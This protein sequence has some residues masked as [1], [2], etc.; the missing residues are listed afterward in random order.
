VVAAVAGL[1][2]VGASDARRTVGRRRLEVDSN[3]RAR[4]GHV[5]E[6]VSE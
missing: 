2:V 5:C 3:C 4:R 1:F 6:R